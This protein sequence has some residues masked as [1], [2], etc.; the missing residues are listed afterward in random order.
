LDDFNP[1]VR[2]DSTDVSGSG[3]INEWE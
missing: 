1:A 2:R 3:V